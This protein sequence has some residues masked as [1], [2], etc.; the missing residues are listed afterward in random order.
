[1]SANMKLEPGI[2]A[3]VIGCRIDPSDIG[4]IVK[5]RE[6]VKAGEST[7]LNN[8]MSKVKNDCWVCIGDNIGHANSMGVKTLGK[9]GLYSSQHLMPIRPEEDPLEFE[10][11]KE[12]AALA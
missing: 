3:M 5:L 2:M 4:K 8:G 10:V 12:N 11:E 7:I 6:F 9:F 1:M